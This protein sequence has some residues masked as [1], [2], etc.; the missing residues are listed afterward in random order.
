MKKL[1][2]AYLVPSLNYGGSE[3]L[4]LSFLKFLDRER[5]EPEVHCFYEE[6]KLAPEF[7]SAGIPV[8]D[9]RSPRRDPVMFFR[10]IRHLRRKKYRIV[11]THLFD[12]QG[13]VAA[14]LAGIPIVITTYHLVTDWDTTGGIASKAL[15]YI[16]S[17]T[18]RL[19]DRIIAVS[20][21]VKRNAIVKGNIPRE[22]IVTVLNGIDVESYRTDDGA[23]RLRKDLD[24]E[25]KRVLLAIGRLVEQKGH[26]YLVQAAR[27][28]RE[29]CP[30][31]AVLIVGEGPLEKRLEEE[32]RENRLDDCVR[33][34][35]PR[36]DIANLFALSE[37][38]VMP[39]LFEGL[40][41]T[42]LEAMAARKPIVATEVEGIRETLENGYD[43]L[44]VPPKDPRSLADALTRILSDKE[45]RDSVSSGAETKAREKFDIRHH[46][47]QVEDIYLELAREKGLIHKGRGRG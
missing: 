34:L 41:I 28:I 7:R 17:L 25:G 45:L 9:W 16:D 47:K 15:V 23:G 22:R 33:L 26:V 10:L 13:R 6:G 27:L 24:L 38:F 44:L 42:L 36:R 12:R 39:S 21:E 46:V 20:E 19:N 29:T 31:V 35:G 37:V 5:F 2:V 30:E 18:S 43:S 3:T 11:H 4:L 32:I 8:R 40:P 1:S 14:F